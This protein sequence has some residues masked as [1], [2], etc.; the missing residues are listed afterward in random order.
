[1]YEARTPWKA[2]LILGKLSLWNKVNWNRD[3]VCTLHWLF[4]VGTYFLLVIY[5][6][7]ENTLN[8]Q[9]F[10]FF[11]ENHE[12]KHKHL[13][14]CSF[15]DAKCYWKVFINLVLYKN[16]DIHFSRSESLTALSPPSESVSL[17]R[18]FLP[19]PSMSED[20]RRASEWESRP[21]HHHHH[22][23]HLHPSRHRHNNA[24]EYKGDIIEN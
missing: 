6:A 5:S 23:H 18:P 24:I 12:H 2:L 7:C 15:K 16:S 10:S 21:H 11:E 9:T 3:W 4:A 13:S 14:C 17:T 8:Q 20:Y 1:M 19:S 22:H